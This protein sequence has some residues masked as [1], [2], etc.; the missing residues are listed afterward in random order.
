MITKAQ[1]KL[2]EESRVD[3]EQGL[4][5]ERSFVS[6]RMTKS[7]ETASQ[8]SPHLPHTV[9]R[10]P[11]ND[12]MV[13]KGSRLEERE[14][15]PTHKSKDELEREGWKAASTTGGQHLE[16]TLEMY[17]ELEMEV[18]LEEVNP[19]ECG[20]CTTCYKE[21]NETMYRIYTRPKGEG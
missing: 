20:E 7:L 4:G 16:R 12:I 6:L 5:K 21:G 1:D 11:R 14:V 9:Q 10:C 18:Y 19:E 2:R 13:E 17:E 3:W 15:P 8:E